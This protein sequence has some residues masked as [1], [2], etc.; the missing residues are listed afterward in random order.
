MYRVLFLALFLLSHLQSLAM[1]PNSENEEI[2]PLVSHEQA[3]CQYLTVGDAIPLLFSHS[4]LET[5]DTDYYK[6]RLLNYVVT[7]LVVP[8]IFPGGLAS[9]VT[10]PNTQFFDMSWCIAGLSLVSF[11]VLVATYAFFHYGLICIGNGCIAYQNDHIA[12]KITEKFIQG[13]ALEERLSERDIQA[14]S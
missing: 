1:E 8:G 4:K 9:L 5:F 12:S 3:A 13:R 10:C 14:I 7:A 2:V 11:P 6:N